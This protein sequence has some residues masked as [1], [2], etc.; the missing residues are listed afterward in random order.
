MIF[1]STLDKHGKSEI[2]RKLWTKYLGSDLCMGKTF[3]V[4]KIFGKIPSSNIKPK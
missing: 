1:S 2:G 3:A 4:L